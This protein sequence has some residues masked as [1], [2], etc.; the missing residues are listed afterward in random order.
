MRRRMCFR[1][2]AHLPLD[3]FDESQGGN[4]SP[5][6]KKCIGWP[7]GMIPVRGMR[8][9]EY[10]DFKIQE[11]MQ[12]PNPKMIHPDQLKNHNRAVKK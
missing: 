9:R 2:G 6:C 4:H 3:D 5:Q 12:K 8:Y 7:V 10:I 11:A 1:C